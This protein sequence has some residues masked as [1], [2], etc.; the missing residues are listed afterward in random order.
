MILIAAVDDSGGM[1]F[2][3]RRQ[4]RDRVLRERILAL[5]GGGVLWMSRYSCGQF[6]DMENINHIRTDDAF[7]D[8]AATGEY[9]FAEDISPAPYSERIEKIILFKWNRRYPADM[10]FGI[11]LSAPEWSLVGTEDFSG[12][13][14]EK[15]TMEVY[16]R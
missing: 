3:N 6:A 16:G 12:S 14:H 2:N 10:Y 1:M 11:D 9:C 4:S 15:I 13:S 7:F 8:K 5:T